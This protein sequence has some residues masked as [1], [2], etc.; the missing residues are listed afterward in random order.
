MFFCQLKI[1][2]G[3]CFK[4]PS[5]LESSHSD[6]YMSRLSECEKDQGIAQIHDDNIQIANSVYL[7]PI[8]SSKIDHEN[9]LG[10]NDNIAPKK[11]LS[12][13]EKIKRKE[14]LKTKTNNVQFV[15]E[16][17]ISE[18]PFEKCYNKR[19]ETADLRKEADEVMWEKKTSRNVVTQDNQK[20]KQSTNGEFNKMKMAL[21]M[22]RAV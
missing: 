5:F 9:N 3:N 21:P 17:D 6:N 2:Q 18:N 1:R 7:F 11:K 10:D 14:S 13:P 12:M 19:Q 4:F 20:G 22:T 16:S 8:C 15:R